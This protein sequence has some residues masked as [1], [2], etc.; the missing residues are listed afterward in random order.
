LI[1]GHV[2]TVRIGL[3]KIVSAVGREPHPAALAKQVAHQLGLCVPSDLSVVGFDDNM[4]ASA[5]SPQLTTVRQPFVQM[6]EVAYQLLADQMEGRDPASVRV[7]L[8][9]TLVIRDSTA[10]LRVASN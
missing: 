10:Q 2:A 1:S 4:Y 5:S 6:G 9:A 8:A 7:E 3:I